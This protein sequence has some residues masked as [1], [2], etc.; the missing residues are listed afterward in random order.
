MFEYLKEFPQFPRELLFRY[1]YFLPELNEHAFWQLLSDIHLFYVNRTKLKVKQDFSVMTSASPK[2]MRSAASL[3]R[4][5]PSVA[6]GDRHQA[7]N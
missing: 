2:K 4:A 3:K 5:Q 1:E 6:A 7:Y